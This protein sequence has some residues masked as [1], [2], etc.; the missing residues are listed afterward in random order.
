MNA[1]TPGPW[2]ITMQGHAYDGD[3]RYQIGT[4][5]KTVAYT[6]DGIRE[7]SD[8][9]KANAR[10]I[11]AAPELLEALRSA[12][13]IIGHPDD[14]MSIYFAELI[15]KATGTTMNT[16]DN[17]SRA[18]SNYDNAMPRDECEPSLQAALDEM[19]ASTY[20]M[21]EWL[22][23]PSSVAELLVHI[24]TRPVPRTDAERDAL[25]T[26]VDAA[27]ESFDDWAQTRTAGG[28]TSPLDRW[29]ED[30]GPY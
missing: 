24:F 13:N 10:L 21:D 14:A 3:F 4:A 8:E 30:L 26:L 7:P 2:S 18:Q 17:F 6:Y 23:C 22:G 11:V 9:H 12:A 27:R 29:C 16:H 15:A 5:S 20:C 25:V 28:P 1:F 19:E